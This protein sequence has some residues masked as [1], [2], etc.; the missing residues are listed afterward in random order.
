MSKYKFGLTEMLYLWHV[1]GDDRV[2]VHQ[3]N[4][5]VILDWPTPKNIME[6]R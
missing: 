3:E 6:L 4:I 1:I 2:R 5:C